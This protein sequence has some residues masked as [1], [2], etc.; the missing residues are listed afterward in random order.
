[1]PLP[2]HDKVYRT[3]SQPSEEIKPARAYC[4]LKR[5]RGVHLVATPVVFIWLNII[6]EIENRTALKSIMNRLR[7]TKYKLR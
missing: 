7:T 5:D 6:H 1:M 3:R 2:R 4:E